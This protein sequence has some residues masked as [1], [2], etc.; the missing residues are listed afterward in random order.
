MLL[1]KQ[2]YSNAA[3]YLLFTKFLIEH[4]CQLD[5][6]EITF[7]FSGWIGKELPPALAGGI[8]EYP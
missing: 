5:N 2:T 4:F 8:N 3:S 6:N 1:F 7:G